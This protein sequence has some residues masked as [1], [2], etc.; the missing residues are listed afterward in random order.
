ML[1]KQ[2]KKGL[3][4]HLPYSYSSNCYDVLV[5]VTNSIDVLKPTQY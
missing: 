5:K 4:T 1:I 2:D 3:G